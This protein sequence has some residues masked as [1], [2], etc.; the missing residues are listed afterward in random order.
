MPVEG[1]IQGGSDRRYLVPREIVARTELAPGIGG[2]EAGII[3]AGALVG[4]LAQ[5]VVALASHLVPPAAHSVHD[6]M[7]MARGLVFLAP[8]G[9]AYVSTR[10]TP[11]G[12]IADYLR[13]M[14]RWGRGRKTFLYETGGDD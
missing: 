11:G 12:S 14:R 3:L 6:A 9:F 8:T 1:Q 4:L 2:I 10:P 7:F 5:W 13:A